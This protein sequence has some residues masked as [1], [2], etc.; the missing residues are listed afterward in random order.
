MD[1]F[2]CPGGHPFCGVHPFFFA[3]SSGGCLRVH[4]FRA[5]SVCATADGGV[6]VGAFEDPES[7]FLKFEGVPVGVFDDP[8]TDL[9][10]GMESCASGDRSVFAGTKGVTGPTTGESQGIIGLRDVSQS[11]SSLH[12]SR[13]IN[14]SGCG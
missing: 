8:E 13:V 1:R 6:P 4:S 12:L 14:S 7:D 3:R 10:K 11:D 5:D 2:W 9:S